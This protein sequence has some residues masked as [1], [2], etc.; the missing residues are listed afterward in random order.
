MN[1]P[2]MK[3]KFSR[4]LGMTGGAVFS[5]GVS[6]SRTFE[7][8]SPHFHLV[9]EWTYFDDNEKRMGWMAALMGKFDFLRKTQW[10]VKYR[11]E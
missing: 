11:I 4:Q 6:D 8:W 10:T 7:T 5:F 3:L 2:Y 1:T 9:D